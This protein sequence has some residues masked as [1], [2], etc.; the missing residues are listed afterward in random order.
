MY[1]IT[2]KNF[3]HD[4]LPTFSVTERETLSC[5]HRDRLLFF[6]RISKQ[7]WH[8]KK[9]QPPLR[10]LQR[11]AYITCAQRVLRVLQPDEFT[12]FRVH[13]RSALSR[14]ENPTTF[15]VGHQCTFDT[16]AVR[17]NRCRILC[18]AINWNSRHWMHLAVYRSSLEYWHYFRTAVGPFP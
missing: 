6:E 18:P 15:P 9:H 2:S 14:T 4:V 17:R 10:I 11:S 13:A 8:S 12:S 7:K 16:L 1:K 5:R 3:A